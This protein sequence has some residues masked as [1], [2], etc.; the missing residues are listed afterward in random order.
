MPSSSFTSTLAQ[1]GNSITYF[2]SFSP[3]TGVIDSGAD[4]M[5]GNKGILSSFDSNSFYPS[6][7]LADDSLSFVQ[8]IGSANTTHSLS[9]SS[10]LYVL[11][12]SLNLVSINKITRFSNCSVTFFL[13]HC[14]F[15]EH[16]TKK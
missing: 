7:T 16:G 5:S 13:T 1:K 12:F 3:Y 8:G 10:M 11:K 6:V 2:T 14:L 15:Q 9:L 4:H